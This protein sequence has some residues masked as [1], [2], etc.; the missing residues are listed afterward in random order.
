MKRVVRSAC[1]LVAAAAMCTAVPAG[2]A[3]ADPIGPTAHVWVTTPDKSQL[4][5]DAGT[6]SFDDTPSGLPTLV[7]D[8]S[9]TFQTMTGFGA[10]LT[11]SSATVL[12]GLAPSA[13][14]AVMR[15][16][17]DPNTGDGL[18][19]LRQPIGASDF[20]TDHDYTYDDMPPGQTDYQQRHFSVAHDQA[21]ILPL[22]RQARAINPHLTVMDA[23]EST[24]MD[25]D[26]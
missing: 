16:L 24:R 13:R 9:R 21:A 3:S 12:S 22:L 19:F 15:D 1:A 18:N 20:V 11:D 26:Q 10:S 6:V 4:L 25:E 8:Q 14:D 23:L 7:V 17:F 2:M 5:H